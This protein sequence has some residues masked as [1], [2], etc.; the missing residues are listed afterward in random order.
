MNKQPQTYY[1]IV[2]VE[3][4]LPDTLPKKDGKYFCKVSHGSIATRKGNLQVCTFERGRFY[5]VGDD[6]SY[7]EEYLSEQQGVILSVEEWEKVQKCI[8]A[9]K[10]MVRCSFD[11]HG[12]SDVSLVENNFAVNAAKQALSQLCECLNQL[13]SHGTR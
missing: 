11:F 6:W 12:K 7:V 1:A 9:L 8:N 5:Q 3:E 4:G 2:S 10:E 13:Q